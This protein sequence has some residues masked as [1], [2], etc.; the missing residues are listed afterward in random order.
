MY[1]FN[2]ERI[3]TLLTCAA[4]ELTINIAIMHMY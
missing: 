4:F 3:Q 2:L 1:G